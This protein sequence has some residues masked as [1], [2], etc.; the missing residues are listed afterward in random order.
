[1]EK[2]WLKRLSALLVFILVVGFV[3]IGQ[4]AA[5]VALAQPKQIVLSWTGDPQTTQTVA[6][7]MYGTTGGKVQYMKESEKTADFKGAQE[8]AAICNNL[9][10]QFKHFEVELDNLQ[11]DTTY[12]YRVGADGHW[13]EPATFKT[14]APTGSFS[15]MFMGD[16]QRGFSEWGQLL[17]KAHTKYP[18]LKFTMLG[19]DLVD[20]AGDPR[21][22][23]D[24]FSAA[25]GV[26][27][28]IPLMPTLGNHENEDPFLYFKSFALP[29]NGPA[30]LKEHHYSFD[31]SDAHFVVLDSNIMRDE[32]ADYEAGIDWL[33]KNLKN[34]NK[35]WKLVMFHHPPYGVYDG[36]FSDDQEPGMIKE[37]WVPV[38]ERNGVNMVFVGHQHMYMR[39]Y[40]MCEGRI[41]EKPTNGITY[42]MGV[43]GSKFYTDPEKH[44][45]IA[46][47]LENVS[48]YT[49]ININGDALKLTT[50]NANGKVLDE[51]ELKLLN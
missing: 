16:V 4:G 35:K 28:H 46:K 9:Y 19:G 39:T 29:Q 33:E 18:D 40:P 21:Q 10:K 24:F 42:V 25:A 47:V 50:M 51:Y 20:A 2:S 11:P 44:D 34:S 5:A 32:G 48:C 14:A 37:K 15:F 43:A 49:V 1:M 22:W 27:D 8:K 23:S 38:L 7:R 45:Y 12:V 3:L 13:S 36:D 41:A 17:H 30:K 31:Y 26:F 6:W